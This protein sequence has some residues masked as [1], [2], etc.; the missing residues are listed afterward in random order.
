MFITA[1][2]GNI[3]GCLAC[4]LFSAMMFSCFKMSLSL[5]N[6][7]KNPDDILGHGIIV[8]SLTSSVIFALIPV[9]ILLMA[10]LE[11]NPHFVDFLRF[12]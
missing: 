4:L 9:G 3:V 8:I 12:A 11:R 7:K 5:V 2:I 1:S 6:P 10:Y